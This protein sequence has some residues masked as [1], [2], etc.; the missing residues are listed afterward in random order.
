MRR[1]LIPMLAVL[2]LVALLVFV[3][4]AP[5]VMLGLR[6]GAERNLAAD[7]IGALPD[8]L[9]V[10]LCGAGGPLP[11]PRRSG[12]C[13]AI[14]A[15]RSLFVVDAGTGGARN[16]GRMG[17][18]PGELA[19][20]FLTHFHSDHIDGL[21][22]L[23]LLRWAGAA[24]ASP[25]P[26]YGPAGVRAVVEGFNRAYH[27]DVG[28]R[29]AHHGAKTVPPDGAGMEARPFATPES[30]APVVVWDAEGVIVTSFR[31]D[32]APVDPAVGYRF[33]YGGRSV[34]VSGDTSKSP[35]L[36]RNAE[37]VD[38][39]VHEA[40]AAHL[41]AVMNEAAS[42]V[43][44]ANLAKIMSDIPSYHATP[45]EVAEIAQAAGVGHL[46]YTHIVP[47]LILP[48]ME[49]LFLQGVSDV[50]AG[51]VTLGRDGT[52]ISLPRVP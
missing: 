32:H 26:V 2:A 1:I 10:V 39:L 15:G 24:K 4:R 40:L 23:A 49:G 37:G 3:F 33:D 9:H 35:E 14:V 13:T 50:Y 46:I 7:P 48:G 51:P 20:A 43:G 11:D 27:A 12:P 45:L 30:G 17:V 19:A 41:V 25:L 16:M 52:K 47:P 42:Q 44:R 18:P 29:V 31:V 21:G 28:Y 22:E 34:L 5:L 8:G 36:Q 6:L 38:V